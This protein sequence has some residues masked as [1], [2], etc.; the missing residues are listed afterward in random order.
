MNFSS[1]QVRQFYVVTGGTDGAIQDVKQ[2]PEGEVY[3]VY[4][5]A[6]DDSML[7]SDFIV[8]STVTYAK[9]IEAATMATK[10][11][12]ISI[13]LATDPIVGQDYVLGINFKN[14]FSSGD[15]SQYYKTAVVHAT[16]E[17]STKAELLKAMKEALDAAFSRE[18]GATKLSNPYLNFSVSGEKLIIEEKEQPWTRDTMKQRR[19][20]FDVFPS[21]V[22]NG[23]EDVHWA[24][25][26]GE[27]YYTEEDSTTTIP[28]GKAIANME[29][30]YLGERGDQYRMAGWPNYIPTKYLVDENKAYD[31]IEIHYAFTDT[32]VNSYRTEKELTI[33]VA[34]DADADGIVSEL[35]EAGITFAKAST[36]GEGEGD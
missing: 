12:K 30:F 5:G 18:D 1:N 9:K 4:R 14:F 31:V 36:G 16:S 15:D 19:I 26:V 35:E 22:Y 17:T 24:T 3:F 23:T 11:R 32:G 6:G 34:S 33:V 10:M 27:K 21:T 8:P 20:Y 13:S 25:K 29:Y 2:T 28:N 7:R